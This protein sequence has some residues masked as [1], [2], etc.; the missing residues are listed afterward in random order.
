MLMIPASLDE[1]R[2][3]DGASGW[4][5][6]FITLVTAGKGWDWGWTCWFE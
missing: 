6:Y 3:K 5:E 1:M 4:D 2:Q